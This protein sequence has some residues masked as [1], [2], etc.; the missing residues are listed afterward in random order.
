V[1]NFYIYY[2]PNNEYNITDVIENIEKS[3][4]IHLND[5]I[6]YTDELGNKVE[7]KENIRIGQLY[8]MILE[9][10]AN[11]YSAVSSNKINNFEF[12]IKCTSYDKYK[13]PHL[14]TSTKTLG[15]T[16]V[17][18]LTALGGNPELIGDLIDLKNL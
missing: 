8:F 11:T 1:D 16:E 2:H 14:L 6:T 10:I 5:K 18:I 3:M 17:R 7:T 12:S 15:K 13:Y 9:K 4:D